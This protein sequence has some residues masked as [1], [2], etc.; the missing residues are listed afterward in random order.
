[1]VKLPDELVKLWEKLWKKISPSI[2]NV[3]NIAKNAK[4]S[5]D[6]L[7]TFI[8]K[9]NVNDSLKNLSENKIINK[10]KDLQ[11]DA[12]KNYELTKYRPYLNWKNIKWLSEK[13][14]SYYIQAQNDEKEIER[15]RWL[16]PANNKEIL[17]QFKKIDM[18]LKETSKDRNWIINEQM[19][20][21]AW[22]AEAIKEWRK[23]RDVQRFIDDYR[24]WDKWESYN[25]NR[26]SLKYLWVDDDYI[27]SEFYRRYP[28]YRRLSF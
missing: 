22:E 27:R 9:Y 6:N 17:S 12:Y 25:Q 15:L 13:P 1:M 8:D 16:L 2:S 19:L 20:L 7:P 3:Y 5:Y 28:E 4:E 26:D 14:D 10:I 18:P 11:K 23:R 24:N 21:L